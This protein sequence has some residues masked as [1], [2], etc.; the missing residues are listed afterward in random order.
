MPQQGVWLRF[1]A[2]EGFER[3]ECRAAATG[4]QNGL[5][6]AAPGFDAGG[7]IG[8]VCMKTPLAL[9]HP[10]AMMIWFECRFL[11]TVLA[12]WRST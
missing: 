8:A 9:C 1:A 10:A 11:K 5:T 3:L 7:A 12:I 4:L 6:V 2:A